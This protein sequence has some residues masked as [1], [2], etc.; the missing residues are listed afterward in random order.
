LSFISPI[1]DKSSVKLE[2]ERA[3][4]V[5]IRLDKCSLNNL[6]SLK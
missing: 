3:V 5:L 4:E 6:G 2:E 1:P